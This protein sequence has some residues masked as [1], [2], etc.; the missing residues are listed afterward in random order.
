MMAGSTGS[1]IA[2]LRKR[3]GPGRFDRSSAICD[4]PRTKWPG[5][6]KGLVS[7]IRVSV[8]QPLSA[9]LTQKAQQLLDARLAFHPLRLPKTKKFVFCSPALSSAQ[10]EIRG[11]VQCGG[12][13]RLHPQWT[14]PWPPAMAKMPQSFSDNKPGVVAPGPLT[15]SPNRPPTP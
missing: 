3:L 1:G 2:S 14:T 11:S 4:K 5:I 7:M 6:Q 15:S 10:R 13:P 12:R 8:L 9:P